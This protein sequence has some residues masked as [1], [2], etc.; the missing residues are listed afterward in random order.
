MMKQ[1]FDSEDDKNKLQKYYLLNRQGG[2]IVD[3]DFVPM[4]QYYINCKIY[5]YTELKDKNGDLKPIKKISNVFDLE[6][7]FNDLFLKYNNNTKQGFGFLIGNYFGEKTE[8]QKSFKNHTVT[9]ETSA[10]FYKYRKSIYNYIYKSR[11]QSITS[12]MFEEMVYAAILSDIAIDEY[13]NEKHSKYY[14]IREKVNLLFSLYDLFNNKNIILMNSK[15]ETLKEKIR[16]IAENETVHIESDEE[17]AFAAGQVVS[18]LLE[19]SEASNKTY[20]M[21]EPFLQKKESA[22]LQTEIARIIDVYKHNIKFYN[23]K[24][25]NFELLSADVLTCDKTI[26]MEP[27]RNFFI[28]GCFT[29]SV[30]R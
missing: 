14:S 23:G 22:S 6:R 4:F 16:I 2:D 9:K 28:A 21:L 7:V 25:Y 12:E 5:N 24:K 20:A 3:I 17:F 8:S 13:K 26:R 30:F 11:L 19:L 29:P 18:H 27:L 10:S 15:I 1:I